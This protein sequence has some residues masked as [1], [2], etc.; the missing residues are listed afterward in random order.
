MKRYRGRVVG[1]A[2]ILTLAAALFA[3][4][5]GFG[6]DDSQVLTPGQQATATRHAA[7]VV[8]HSTQVSGPNAT[9]T[10]GTMHITQ[11]AVGA[12]AGATRA[13][14]LVATST[15]TMQPTSSA[16]AGATQN[17]TQVPSGTAT[18]E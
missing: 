3:P 1:L 15:A 10:A 6:L 8:A 2:L 16:T 14:T 7:T 9:A 12:T 17:A 11:T 18:A 13:V 5:I 4:S